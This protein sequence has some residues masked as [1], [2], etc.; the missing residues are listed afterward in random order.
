MDGLY[1]GWNLER[2]ITAS[3][4]CRYC[5]CVKIGYWLLV[6]IHTRAVFSDVLS[7][8]GTRS[9][10]LT[11][12]PSLSFPFL[13]EV[14]SV[15]ILL[16][17]DSVVPW[18]SEEMAA[19]AV[20]GLIPVLHS[21]AGD[22]SG[23]YVGWHLW[24]G[25]IA[26]YGMVLYM[27][28]MPWSSIHEHFQCHG[29]ITYACLTECF[30]RRFS[31]PVVGIWYFF[32]FVFLSLFFLMEF[33]MAQIRHKQIKLKSE[34]SVAGEAE[35]GSM[36]GIQEQDRSPK[37]IWT[38]PRRRCFP[39]CTSFTSCCRSAPRVCFY[40]FSCTNHC[41]WWA[42]PSFTAAPRPALHPLSASSGQHGETNGPLHPHHLVL[43]DHPLLLGFLHVQ[44]SSLPVKGAFKCEVLA[45]LTF[46]S[47]YLESS[48]LALGS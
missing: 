30:E 21:V 33:F 20:A 6:R 9:P 3:W 48:S 36:V 22:K 47:S 32:F 8:L 29:N 23:C 43:H 26:M 2:G 7:V 27:V 19:A 31:S 37:S 11:L 34:E 4:E 13:P 42:T 45:W 5:L 40:S 18:E 35:E 15:S 46:G 28:R 39:F 44:H 1:H 16:V 14:P 10:V 25:F 17:S 38:S 24:F 41:Q 12:R